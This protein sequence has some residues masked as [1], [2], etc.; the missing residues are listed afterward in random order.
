M[1][2]SYQ[3]RGQLPIRSNF[4]PNYARQVARSLA[5]SAQQQAIEDA[6]GQFAR[7]WASAGAIFNRLRHEE[8]LFFPIEPAYHV[9]LLAE[10]DYL[11]AQLGAILGRQALILDRLHE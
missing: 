7:N 6:L 1:A 2:V 4:K 10:L 11:H 5:H 9:D 3:I 8:P